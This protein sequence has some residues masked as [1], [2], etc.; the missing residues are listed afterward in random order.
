MCL[1]K[2]FMEKNP[3]MSAARLCGGCRHF[4]SPLGNG[5]YCVPVLIIMEAV[6]I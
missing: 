1:G 3:K 6:F 2:H 5:I 4:L